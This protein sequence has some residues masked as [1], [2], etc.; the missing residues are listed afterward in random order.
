MS[1]SEFRSIGVYREL[2]ETGLIALI[3]RAN[4]CR[5]LSRPI[6]GMPFN[7]TANLTA[8]NVALGSRRKFTVRSICELTVSLECEVQQPRGFPSD[9]RVGSADGKFPRSELIGG[10]GASRFAAPLRANRA[11]ERKGRG[12]N[13]FPVVDLGNYI[14]NGNALQASIQPQTPSAMA[15]L[16][17]RSCPSRTEPTT[18]GY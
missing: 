13:D 3:Q 17:D 8:K 15:S 14:I 2:S 16:G 9:Q 11:T 18:T 6:A 12:R 7:L 1:G 4:V 5:D 10:T